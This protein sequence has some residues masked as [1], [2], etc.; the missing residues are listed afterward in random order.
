MRTA[1]SSWL[2]T[3]GGALLL[4]I[5]LGVWLIPSWR[6]SARIDAV[7]SPDAERRSAAWTWWNTAEDGIVPR[8]ATSLETLNGVLHDAPDEALLHGA[9]QLQRIGCW[10]WETQPPRLVARHL[11]LLN[12]RGHVLDLEDVVRTLEAA[13]LDADPLHVIDPTV[14]ILGHGDPTTA[15]A[16]FTSLAA[17]AG[18]TPRLE[19][20]LDRLPPHRTAWAEPYRAWL[21]DGPRPLRGKASPPDRTAG[22]DIDSDDRLVE[23]VLI[24]DAPERRDVGP[25]RIRVRL[26]D[27]D[28]HRRRTAA[29]LAALR[30][31]DGTAV[32]E[33]MLI[34]R[35]PATRLTMR[36]ALD[37]L[38][39]PT[40]DDDPGE[41]AWRAMHRTPDRLWYP[42][43]LTRLISGDPS[44]MQPLLEDCLD[45]RPE[46]RAVA[47][48]LAHRFM[49]N[50]VAP[51]S[52]DGPAPIA[53]EDFF[54]R[55]LARWHLER[56]RLERNESGM[57]ELTGL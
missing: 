49:P 53:A 27:A 24:P 4:G 12:R 9:D 19:L 22:D 29:L 35:D 57:Y 36:L 42:P 17:W 20:V 52:G 13:P 43:I 25:E 55:L 47:R 41:F 30:G 6:D 31:E 37:A 8:A 21:A 16:V 2:I 45:D 38:D 26:D 54:P 34:E 28:P 51:D 18:M 44:L 56:R 11:R 48:R 5:V 32:A 39:R 23:A 14:S 46:A 40:T 7:A 50:W 3:G 1:E 15:D 33:A 10:G